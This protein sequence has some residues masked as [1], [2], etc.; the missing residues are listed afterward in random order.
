MISVRQFRYA[1]D[2]LAY[3]IYGEKEA[4]AVDG[5]AV[6]E[7]LSFVEE[8]GVRLAYVLNT[9][10]HY[11][12]TSGNQALLNRSRALFL[13]NGSLRKNGFF[14]VDGNRVMV[15]HTPGHM[16]DCLIFKTG[17]YLITG[18]TLFTGTVGNCFSGD[19]EGFFKSIQLIQSFP[20]Q[21]IIYPG[22]DYVRESLIYAKSLEPDNPDIARFLEAYDPE[23]VFSTLKEEMKINPYLRLNDERIIQMLD[24]EGLPAGTEYER[25]VSLM[26]AT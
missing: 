13:D 1:S 12:H 19:L 3:L 26:Q 16:E 14:T 18:D 5:G 2:N 11:D 4:A 20:P 6:D 15:Y 22:H 24:A 9:H 21:T 25:W 10:S 8:K 7:I 17:D 23:H